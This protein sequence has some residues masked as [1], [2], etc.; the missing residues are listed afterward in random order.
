ML[1]QALK[2]SNDPELLGLIDLFPQL[3]IG[4][5]QNSQNLTALSHFPAAKQA[6]GAVTH[7]RSNF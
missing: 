6:I 7:Q 3:T 4:G 5:A 1:L 2:P